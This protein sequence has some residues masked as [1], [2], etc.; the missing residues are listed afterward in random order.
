MD[1]P[2]QSKSLPCTPATARLRT[3]GATEPEARREF[4]KYTQ[5]EPHVVLRNSTGD[6]YVAYGLRADCQAVMK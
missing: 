6:G 2:I 4:R 1:E 5:L 3:W